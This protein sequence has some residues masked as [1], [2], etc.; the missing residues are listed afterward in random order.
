[1][2][3][4]AGISMVLV[5]IM[6][7]SSATIV[8]TLIFESGTLYMTVYK[9]ETKPEKYY[10]IITPD[11][12]FTKAVSSVGEKICFNN[13]NE[14]SIDDLTSEYETNTVKY[15]NNFYNVLIAIGEP[16][17]YFFALRQ[18]SLLGLL[19]SAGALVYLASRRLFYRKKANANIE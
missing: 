13:L 5:I 14:T 8:L 16:A 17:G 15:E 1:L 9:L 11:P 10:D 12:I 6:V 4:L 19:L 2:K 7:L 3:K 18:I